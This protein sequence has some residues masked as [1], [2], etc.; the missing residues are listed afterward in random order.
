M[1]V[2]LQKRLIYSRL[3]TFCSYLSRTDQNQPFA[4]EDKIVNNLIYGYPFFFPIW[5]SPMD[6]GKTLQESFDDGS[7]SNVAGFEGLTNEQMAKA[8]E[9]AKKH[10][11]IYA[12][13]DKK[14]P[15]WNESKNVVRAFPYSYQ[16]AMG[17]TTSIKTWLPRLV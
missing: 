7:L 12:S 6:Q 2:L 15:K 3:L 13:G 9:N 10:F 14:H 16:E 11:F 5:K 4:M 17:I 1:S 8:L